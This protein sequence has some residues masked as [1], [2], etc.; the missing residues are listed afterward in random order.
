MLAE[1]PGGMGEYLRQGAIDP[2]SLITVSLD[3]NQKAIRTSS[4]HMGFA[5]DLVWLLGE[6]AA[7][8]LAHHLQRRVMD[9]TTRAR[10]PSITESPG[11]LR[12]LA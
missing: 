6:L 10:L 2:G 3:R 11:G 7:A 5:P 9:S 12:S 8:P 4:L 1:T